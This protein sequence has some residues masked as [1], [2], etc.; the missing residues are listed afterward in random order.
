M[1]EIGGPGLAFKIDDDDKM[2]IKSIAF[3]LHWF[4]GQMK[5]PELVEAGVTATDKRESLFGET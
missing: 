1:F 3:Q 5:Y 2:S 4:G